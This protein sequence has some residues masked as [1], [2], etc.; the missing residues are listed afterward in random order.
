M[1]RRTDSETVLLSDVLVCFSSKG[2][3]NKTW[4]ETKSKYENVWTMMILHQSCIVLQKSGRE[5]G[6]PSLVVWALLIVTKVK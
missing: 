5:N 4:E 3:F 6:L 2:H 1:V